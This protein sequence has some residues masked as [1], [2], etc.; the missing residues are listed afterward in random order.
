MKGKHCDLEKFPSCKNCIC[1]TCARDNGDCCTDH[2]DDLTCTDDLEEDE[3]QDCPDF[4]P[5]TEE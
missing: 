4:T 1:T 5:E 2:E 3:A